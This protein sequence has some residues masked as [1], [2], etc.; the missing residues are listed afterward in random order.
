MEKEVEKKLDKQAELLI[1]KRLRQG[2]RLSIIYKLFSIFPIRNN[3]IVFTTFEGIGGYCCSPKYIAEELLSRSQAHNQAHKTYFDI[4][5]LT[6]DVSKNFPANI[7]KVQNTFLNRAYHLSTAKFWVDNTR[8]PLGTL[9][10]KNQIYIQTWHASLGFKPIGKYRG[11][12][13]PKIAEII[14]SKDAEQTDY[15]IS[16]SKWQTEKIP[17]MMLYNGEIIETGTPRV[18]ILINDRNKT[19]SEIRKRYNLPAD[20]KIVLYAPTFRGGS[21]QGQRSIYSE[22]PTINFDELLSTLQKK[23]SGE[24]FLFLR[25]HPQLSACMDEMPVSNKPK[26]LVDVSCADDMNELIAGSDIFITDYSS[27][28]FDASY[29]KMPVFLYADDL[30]DYVNERGAFMW[31]MKKLPFALSENSGELM[32]SILEFD[33]EEYKTVLTEFL[34]HEQVTEDGKASKRIVDLIE[35]KIKGL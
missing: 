31:D 23:F 24:W 11:N 6:N 28:A 33:E 22:L 34:E 35:S 12:A 9:K 20:C 2:K 4:I 10:R 32:K 19:Y 25:M 7:K 13:F 16:N 18:D 27:A 30:A 5:W 8:K 1:K 3:K 15:V 21:Q 17:K 26:N 29:I 14:S